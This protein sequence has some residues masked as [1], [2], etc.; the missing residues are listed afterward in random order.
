MIDLNSKSLISDRINH[1]IDEVL[2]A[3][4]KKEPAR[5]YLGGSCLGA[6]YWKALQRNKL[7]K[8]QPVYYAQ[9]QTYQKHFGLTENPALF[10]AVCADDMEI[11]WESIPHDSRFVDLLDEK[12]KR[13][14]EACMHE[15]LLPR[16]RNDPTFYICKMCD[17]SGRC[18]SQ[19]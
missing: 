9:V 6:K 5:D 18:Y 4:K 14:I 3:E 12:A 17:W 8:E 15:E 19:N 11:Y 7:K 10:S 1:Y 2:V 16:F 13:I